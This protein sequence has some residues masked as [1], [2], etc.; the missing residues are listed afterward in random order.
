MSAFAKMLDLP[1]PDKEAIS[2]AI[3]GWGLVPWE[4]ALVYQIMPP[5]AMVKKEEFDKYDN[6]I[7][8][9]RGK[10]PSASVLSSEEVAKIFFNEAVK[11]AGWQKRLMRTVYSIINFGNGAL[12]LELIRQLEKQ[13]LAGINF[14]KIDSEIVFLLKRVYIILSCNFFYRLSEDQQNIFLHSDLV[15]LA[16]RLG[17][18]FEVVIKDCIERFS[19]LFDGRK[20][21]CMVFSGLLVDNGTIVGPPNDQGLYDVGY[22]INLFANFSQTKISDQTLRSFLEDKKFITG[23]DDTNKYVV[24]IILSLYIHL[25]DG[26]I[27]G[28]NTY[29]LEAYEPDA[30]SEIVGGLLLNPLSEKDKQNIRSWFSKVNSDEAKGFIIYLLDIEGADT[31][32]EP[33]FS[34]LIDFNEMY[35]DYY[36]INEPL[37][38]FDEAK[39]DFILNK[40]AEE[41]AN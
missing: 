3:K 6:L 11:D 4:D 1:A 2:K 22:W 24:S 15:I 20:N 29:E 36:K 31:K 18:D 26:S 19:V 7:K 30:T 12:A 28:V 13:S 16:I 10:D 35:L 33:L 41:F 23:I 40:P 8:I 21:R 37:F 27:M 14:Q 9:L 5:T 32:D 17:F 39:H 38:Y 34:N 25:S